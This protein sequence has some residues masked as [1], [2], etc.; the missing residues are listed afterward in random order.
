M[1]YFCLKE[2]G[3]QRQASSL[4]AHQLVNSIK[5]AKLP[6]PYNG[7]Y[8]EMR[9][10]NQK[11]ER[12]KLLRSIKDSEWAVKRASSRKSRQNGSLVHNC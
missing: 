2:Y 5:V 10:E 4:C 3:A 6:N 11:P 7:H 8:E 12:K 1:E 9:S